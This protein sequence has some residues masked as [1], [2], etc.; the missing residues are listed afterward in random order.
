MDST[1]NNNNN[2]KKSRRTKHPLEKSLAIFPLVP[3]TKSLVY[4][5]F[6]SP[7]LST[8]SLRCSPAAASSRRRRHNGASNSA[9]I[10]F[11]RTSHT[12]SNQLISGING[13]SMITMEVNR[14]LIT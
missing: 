9:T 12:T 8:S 14:I 10:D 5:P 4:N 13:Y 3:R 1:D 7:T 11:N 2:N 6:A